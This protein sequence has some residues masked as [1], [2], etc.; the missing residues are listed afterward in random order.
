[1]IFAYFLTFSMLVV[2]LLIVGSHLTGQ[3]VFAQGTTSTY[4]N[5]AVGLKFEYPS[6]WELRENPKG[7][8]MTPEEDIT[9]SLEVDSL[10]RL[11]MLNPNLKDFA[12]KQYL[13]CCGTMS[14]AIND[15]QTTIGHNYTAL[16]YEYTL[17]G[18]GTRQGLVVWVIN[19]GV[20][21]QFK[22]ISN[23]G[24]EFSEKEFSENL[25][26]V[27]KVLD[28]V[29]FIPVEDQKTKEPQFVQ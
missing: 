23:Q 2:S 16:Q 26:A 3:L 17:E 29:K 18:Q 22:Y 5:P 8:T 13:L 6:E 4:E 27:R 15:N 24:S 9:F 25:P 19:N 21:Y 11:P 28:S 20:G 10:Y 14:N 7:L 12:H 1:M